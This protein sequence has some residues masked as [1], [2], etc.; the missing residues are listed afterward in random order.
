VSD[1]S[2]FAAGAPLPSDTA[3]ASELALAMCPPIPG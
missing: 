1:G 2:S 3:V